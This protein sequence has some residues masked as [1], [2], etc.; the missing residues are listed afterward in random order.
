MAGKTENPASVYATL[1]RSEKCTETRGKKTK[2]AE[3]LEQRV[4]QEDADEAYHTHKISRKDLVGM[5]DT[6]FK[7]LT[8]EQLLQMV[9]QRL[10]NSLGESLCT[11][12]VQNDTNGELESTVTHLKS[13]LD[14]RKELENV[15]KSRNVLKAAILVFLY[16]QRNIYPCLPNHVLERQY[17]VGCYARALQTFERLKLIQRVSGN[18]VAYSFQRKQINRA[19]K[20]AHGRDYKRTWFRVTDSGERLIR[21]KYDALAAML[22]AEAID[23][24]A[25]GDIYARGE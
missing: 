13:I 22:P 15:T 1:W 9:T 25:K 23:R 5:L 18:D 17:N 10:G 14:A 21:Q 11:Y 19:A 20:A 4:E 8:P 16:H 24:V 3:L 12:F 7:D 2:I 6:V